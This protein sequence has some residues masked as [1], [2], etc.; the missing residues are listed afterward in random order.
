MTTMPKVLPNDFG[1]RPGWKPD[2]CMY[3]KQKVGTP[4]LPSCVVVSKR[5]RLR[6]T[7][8]IERDEPFSWGK[9]DL[10][11]H[12][13]AG[14]F[15]ADNFAAMIQEYVTELGSEN[16]LC[17]S[18]KCEFMGVVDETPRAKEHK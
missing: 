1:I 13:N 8:D 6:I 5:V 2:E 14:S 11:S 17:G 18:T 12:Y 16:C 4:H 10:E 3:C 7:I 9:E 15:C